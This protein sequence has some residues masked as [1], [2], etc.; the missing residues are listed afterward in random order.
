M[1]DTCTISDSDFPLCHRTKRHGVSYRSMCPDD[2][3]FLCALYRSTREGELARTPWT[4]AQKREFIEMQ[5]AAQH[6]HYQEHY[7]DAIW[8]VIEVDSRPV[9]RLYMERWADEHR[10][11]DIALVPHMRGNGI[12]QAILEDLLEDAKNE[13]K[14]VGI[15]VEKDN[16]AM[17]L[18]RRLG[19]QTI[20]DKGVYDLLRCR[21]G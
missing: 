20:A 12:G 18:Y 5:F 9:G 17:R 19:F 15:H 11:I 10:I 14:A 4:E 2:M 8:L 13:N 3:P 1:T 16:P 21:P 6:A 7:P